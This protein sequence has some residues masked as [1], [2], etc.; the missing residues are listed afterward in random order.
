MRVQL[1]HKRGG[2]AALTDLHDAWVPNALSGIKEGMYVRARV[3]KYDGDRALLSL[4]PS[5]GGL[6]PGVHK[7]AAAA[8][9]A[10]G[11]GVPAGELSVAGLTRGMVLS[12]YVKRA[13]KSGVFVALDRQAL[14]G[15]PHRTALCSCTATAQMASALLTSPHFTSPC[16]VFSTTLS[17]PFLPPTHTFIHERCHQLA[18]LAACYRPAICL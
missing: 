7:K 4:R 15:A 5:R 8:A 12:G 6:I 2:R 10:E 17:L 13:E 1:G 18:C 16:C 11:A 9:A 3:E 14:Q